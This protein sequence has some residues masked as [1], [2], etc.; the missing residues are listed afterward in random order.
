[1][2]QPP[3]IDEHERPPDGRLV[4]PGLQ[5]RQ[6]DQ[7]GDPDARRTRPDED[8]PRLGQ[9]GPEGA[10]PGQDSRHHDRGGSLDVVVERRHAGL[11]P[12]QDPQGVALLEVLPLDHA[13]RPDLG[14]AR[15]E[16]LDERVVLGPSKPWALDS[17]SRAD[18]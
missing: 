8:D 2:D 15:D 5:H 1:M 4:H 16:R 18:R 9:G 14:H 13:A 12:I 7:P 10:Q 11:V 6:P 3:R 17:R